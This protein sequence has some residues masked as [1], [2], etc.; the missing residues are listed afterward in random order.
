[1]RRMEAAHIRH[2]KTVNGHLDYPVYCLSFDKTGQYF[3][4][5]ADD[6]LAKIWGWATG[7]L[8][9]SLRG[10][11]N[12]ISDISVSCDNTMLATA[13]DDT[14][15]RV[16]ELVT[17]APVV[18]LQGHEAVV[19]LVSFHPCHNVLI[20]V[21]DDGMCILWDLTDRAHLMVDEV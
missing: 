9:L 18:V 17:G 4:T 16:W 5:G 11:C 10:H 20:S 6:H 1:M 7:R 19:N 14:S 8:Q 3:I 15:I 12:V 2:V 21:G 13:S